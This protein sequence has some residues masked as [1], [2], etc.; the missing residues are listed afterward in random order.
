VTDSLGR[1]VAIVAG[2]GTGMG[3]AI[4]IELAKDHDVVIVGRRK[5]RLDEVADH[6]GPAIIPIA[7]DVSEVD[8]VEAV[9]EAVMSTQGRID[10]LVNCVGVRAA[11]VLTTT[12]LREAEEIWTSS[13]KAIATSQ[14]LMCYAV[15][16]H[17]TRPGGRILNFTSEGVYTGGIRPGNPAYIAAKG[18]VQAMSLCLARELSPEGIT[19]NVVVPGIIGDTDIS[20]QLT[21]E[22]RAEYA[23]H[24][25]VGRIGRPEEI[26][27]GVRYLVS[28]DSG[29]VTGQM[30]TIN[31]GAVLGR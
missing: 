20:G 15:A 8:A 3:R 11:R 23:S 29:F 24:T 2:G 26:A 5:E 16:Q 30:L 27:A 31:G 10:V 12:A 21:D 9:V 14:F 17:L 7:A 19:V 25:L 18:A 22:G 6:V 1:P 4:A 28:P 13:L